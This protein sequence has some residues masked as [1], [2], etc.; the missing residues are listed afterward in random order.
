MKSLKVC[1]LDGVHD[2]AVDV[3]T[4]AGFKNIHLFPD[5]LSPEKLE[6]ELTDAAI[7]GIRSKTKLPTEVLMKAPNLLC[8]GRYGI[9]VD[10]VDLKTAQELGIP[11]FNGPHAS[12]RSVAEWV[13]GSTFALFRKLTEKTGDLQSGKWTKSGKGCFEVRGKT[14]GLIGYGNIAAQIS[15]MAE[16]L[17]MNVIYSDIRKVLP[18]GLAEQRPF[19]EVLEKADV[20]SLHVP[21]LPST[22]DLMNADTIG[23]MKKGSFFINSSRGN[24]VNPEAL[25]LALESGHLLGAALDVFVD[26]PKKNS[27]FESILRGIP[28]VVLTPHIAGSTEESQEALGS[29]VSEKMLNYIQLGDSSM[30]VNFPQIG[31]GTPKEGH[32]R[33][34]VIHKN[35]P[36]VLAQINSVLAEKN[37]NVA[38][39]ILQT[40]DSIGVVA[41]DIGSE[42]N[43]FCALL[44]NLD[45]VIKCRTI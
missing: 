9:G 28:N 36:G 3:F 18:L 4:R 20:V 16:A 22:R 42:S 40:Y 31:L 33:I 2:A 6:Q 23:M 44:M 5:S 32:T 14:M 13:M 34:L 29:E 19:A 17:G 43:D 15:I 25:K 27:P 21:G 24:V 30:A 37:I 45:V 38:S 12:T 11:V 35:Q 41:L 1:L 7:V 8:V 10:N 26:E 39:E